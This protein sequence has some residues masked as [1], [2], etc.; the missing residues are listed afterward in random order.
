MKKN[1]PDVIHLQD[2]RLLPQG[3]WLAEQMQCP[4][5][6][7]V[8]DHM[9]AA[10]LN[11]DQASKWLKAIISVSESVKSQIPEQARLREIEQRVIL[12]G[13]SVCDRCGVETIVGGW[14]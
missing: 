3:R 10:S 1:P 7:S 6:I 12:P 2:P 8:N 5:V 14:P 4:M 11:L 9:E 13:V